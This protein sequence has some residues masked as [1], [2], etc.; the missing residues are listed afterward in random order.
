MTT[1]RIKIPCLTNSSCLWGVLIFLELTFYFS[2]LVIKDQIRH[3]PETKLPNNI[4]D[5]LKV[6]FNTKDKWSLDEITPFVKNMT[7]PKLNVK[8]LLTKYARACNE[9]GQKMFTSKHIRWEL[10]LVLIN[11]VNI[12]WWNSLSKKLKSLISNYFCKN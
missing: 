6:L 8:A 11:R 4:Q 12:F 9:N 1:D 3:F 7:T 5:R 2:F 10:L